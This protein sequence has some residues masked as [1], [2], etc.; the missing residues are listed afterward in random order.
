[1]LFYG[2]AGYFAL[3]WWWFKRSPM[4]QWFSTLEHELI[5]ALFA[6]LTLNRVTGLNATSHAGGI[7]HF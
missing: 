5:H 2:E 3:S 7:T 4:G 1:M 6:V